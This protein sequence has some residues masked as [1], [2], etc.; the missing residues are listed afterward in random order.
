MGP[1]LVIGAALIALLWFT[2]WLTA[3]RLRLIGA[4]TLAM[5]GLRVLF[6]GRPLVAAV[7]FVLAGLGVYASRQPRK[8]MPVDD[9]R[10][11]LGVNRTATEAEI[12]AAYR[13]LIAEAHPDKGGSDTLSSQLNAA[14]DMLLEQLSQPGR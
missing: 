5:V 1:V 6:M 4:A 2:G 9:A 14:R 13:R 12:N 3:A 11:L 10:A 7:L 8:P